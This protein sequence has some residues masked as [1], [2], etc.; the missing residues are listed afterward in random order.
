MRLRDLVGSAGFAVALAWR[1]DRRALVQVILV[2]L[3][4][5]AGL[6]AMLL[7]LRSALTDVLASG[8]GGA[9]ESIDRLI[10]AMGTV[11]AFTTL[12]AILQIIGAARQRMLAARVDRQVIAMVLRAAVDAELPQFERPRF[13]DRLQRAVFAS[14][15]E[16]AAVVTTL[17][18]AIQAVL[19]ATAVTAAFVVMAWWLVPFALLAAVPGLKAARDERNAGYGLHR[20]LAENR[21]RREYLERLLTG[22]DEAKE[23]RALDLGRLLTERWD[24][25]YEHEIRSTAAMIGVHLRHK[26]VARLVGAVVTAAVVAAVWWLVR[27]HLVGLPA[28]AAGLVGLWLLSAR[29]QMVGGMFNNVGESVLYLQDLRTFTRTADDDRGADE[30]EAPPETL[31]GRAFGDLHA[32]RIGFTYP[33]SASPALHDV[34]ITLRE[35]EIV[36]LVGANGSGKTTLSKVLGGLYRPDTGVLRRAGVPVHDLKELR[37][38][39][40]TVFQDFTRYRLPAVDNIAF[41]R[42]NTPTDME[43][44]VHAARQAGAHELLHG[45]PDG[46]RTVLSKEFTAGADLSGGQWQ[47]LALAR[48]FYREAPFVILDEPTAA[49]DP[50]AE[51]DL[52]AGIR[53]LFIGRTVLLVSH[54]FSSVRHADRIYVLD[55][56][57]VVEEGTHESLMREAGTY[58]RFFRLQATAYQE[59]HRTVPDHAT[60]ATTGSGE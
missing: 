53:E 28:A 14:R 4:G 20:T 5:A 51:A 42:P 44:V 15:N 9:A 21:R 11:V 29:I 52:F 2:Q 43:R 7:L 41:G 36:A 23:I 24:G 27:A 6:L 54:R 12:G 31:G 55:A 37:E 33:G 40:A 13:H 38:S 57:R 22:R 16:P 47:R 39:A 18:A 30:R 25:E 46:Y 26:I 10:P 35:G 1:A 3:A 17:V 60:A 8:A 58:A 59:P 48:A 56:G 34:N 45:L 49:L 32:E 19:V 50:Q